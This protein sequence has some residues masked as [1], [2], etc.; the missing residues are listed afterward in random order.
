MCRHQSG[1]LRGE[2]AAGQPRGAHPEVMHT[3][4]VEPVVA[5]CSDPGVGLQAVR[6]RVRHSIRTKGWQKAAPF[7]WPAQPCAAMKAST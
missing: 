5:C 7:T 4:G 6:Q 2:V 3:M 1:K